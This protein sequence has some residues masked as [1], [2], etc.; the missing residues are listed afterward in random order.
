MEGDAQGNAVINYPE[1]GYAWTRKIEHKHFAPWEEH[2]RT[3]LFTEYSKET[4]PED[5]PYYPK[6]LQRDKDILNRY[7]AL[8]AREE[9]LVFLG[10]L[11]RYQYLDM[12][13]TIGA[14]LEFGNRLAAEL[15]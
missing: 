1:L 7:Q 9:K 5:L 15:S 8:A 6:R 4:G 3:V 11:G 10:R 13:D 12:D 14:A 2:A